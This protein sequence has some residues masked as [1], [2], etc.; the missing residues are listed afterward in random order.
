MMKISVWRLGIAAGSI[1]MAASVFF[2]APL[3]AQEPLGLDLGKDQLQASK[4]LDIDP[5]SSSLLSQ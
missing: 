2:L 3:A 1:V 4:V 5:S